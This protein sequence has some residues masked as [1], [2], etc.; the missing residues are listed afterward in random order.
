MS[1]HLEEITRG[2]R[3]LRRRLV[4][5]STDGF[6]MFRRNSRDELGIAVQR[7]LYEALLTVSRAREPAK[8]LLKVISAFGEAT[9]TSIDSERSEWAGLVGPRCPILVVFIRKPRHQISRYDV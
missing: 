3:V 4:T 9:R 7:Y 1:P 8:T 6:E 5:Y 2:S